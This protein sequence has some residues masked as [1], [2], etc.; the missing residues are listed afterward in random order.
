MSKKAAKKK[1]LSHA[2]LIAKYDTG[3]KLNFDKA[4][5]AMLKTPSG[6]AIAKAK[7][8]KH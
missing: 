4:I 8:K 2:E 6:F 1:G 3:K 5:K 7:N